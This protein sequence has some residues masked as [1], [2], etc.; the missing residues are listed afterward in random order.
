M[1]MPKGDKGRL[2][3]V[4]VTQITVVKTHLI[5]PRNMCFVVCKFN[6][7]KLIKKENLN[8]RLNVTTVLQEVSID[9]YALYLV[10]NNQL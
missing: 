8:H 9:S 3:V 10:L 6:L 1:S 5:M 4:R 7:V 2:V